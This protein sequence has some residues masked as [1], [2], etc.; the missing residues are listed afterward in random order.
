MT[1]LKKFGNCFPETEKPESQKIFDLIQR[2]GLKIEPNQANS[3][4][5]PYIEI[6][7]GTD[8]SQNLQLSLKTRQ[9]SSNE[10]L[11]AVH[12]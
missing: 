2:I 12:F 8:I 5:L 3:F 1:C 7:K 10:L 11:H 4:D 9:H 6:L